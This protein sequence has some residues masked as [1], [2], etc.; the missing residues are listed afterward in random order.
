MGSAESTRERLLAAMND[1]VADFAASA[2]SGRLWRATRPYRSVKNWLLALIL[3]RWLETEQTEVELDHFRRDSVLYQPS[4]WSWLRKALPASDVGPADV[5]VDFGSGKGRIVFQAARYPFARVVGVEISERLNRIARANIDRNRRRLR[6]QNI[7]LVTADAAAF[8]VP[9][10]MTVA[11]FYY[12]FAG[13][14]FR[15]V[16]A[17]IVA[18]IDRNPRRVTLIYAFPKLG[19][20]IL[21]TGRFVLKRTAR[22]RAWPDAVAFQIAVYVSE[23]TAGASSG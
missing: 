6:C 3:E 7:E 23:P 5:F 1:P 17:K 18:S 13:E 14:T 4:A 21:E 11:Y 22:S 15:T 10:D 12:P 8:D 19:D 16:I 9:D 20:V 2:P